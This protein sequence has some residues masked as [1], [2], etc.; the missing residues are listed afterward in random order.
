[1]LRTT[2]TRT[3]GSRMA[4]FTTLLSRQGGAVG[5]R[6][7]Q[8]CTRNAPLDISLSR[9]KEHLMYKLCSR[10]LQY[11][12]ATKQRKNISSSAE[13]AAHSRQ[14][15]S[16]KTPPLPVIA[17]D[18]R[19]TRK[20]TRVQEKAPVS[21][22]RNTRNL[23]TTR[24]LRC[25]STHICAPLPTARN[26]AGNENAATK[27]TALNAPP[28]ARIS[29]NRGDGGSSSSRAYQS[30]TPRLRRPKTPAPRS[31]L[32]G[33]WHWVGALATESVPPQFPN[34]IRGLMRASRVLSKT[35]SKRFHLLQPTPTADQATADVR[36]QVLTKG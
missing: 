31:V 17:S 1:M 8:T 19:T 18:T 25:S 28:F 20:A 26:R 21:E 7:Y 11:D 9:K 3:N 5:G 34:N 4:V 35:R 10:V 14:E 30:E 27:Q 33:G 16:R 22:R 12:V 13:V 24:L 6:R 36:T 23:T 32:A 15:I 29:A 2:R